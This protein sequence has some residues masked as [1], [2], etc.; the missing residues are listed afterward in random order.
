M[1][2]EQTR[3]ECHISE[4]EPLQVVIRILILILEIFIRGGRGGGGGCNHL[5]P[6]LQTVYRAITD[7]YSPP[8]HIKVY[9]TTSTSYSLRYVW[10]GE[11]T[12]NCKEQID[13]GTVMFN[14][15]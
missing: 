14:E 10:P 6:P 1:L 7:S 11:S 8:L 5:P 4:Q 2:S 3:G 9:Y 15:T 12:K 13:G